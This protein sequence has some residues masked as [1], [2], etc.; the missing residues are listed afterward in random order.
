MIETHVLTVEMSHSPGQFCLYLSHMRLSF[1]FITE[2][3]MN[4]LLFFLTDT[5]NIFSFMFFLSQKETWIFFFFILHIPTKAQLLK[6]SYWQVFSYTFFSC[7]WKCF[8]DSRENYQ[9]GAILYTPVWLFLVTPNQ[10][11]LR[12]LTYEPAS[13]PSLA[14]YLQAHHPNPRGLK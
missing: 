3:E 13:L 1:V 9:I 11:I 5:E 6:K 8:I 7:F 10:L 2:K 4:A 12:Y 14:F